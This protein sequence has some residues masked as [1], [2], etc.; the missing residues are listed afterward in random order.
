MHVLMP[1][2]SSTELYVPD[3]ARAMCY[4]LKYT[5]GITGKIVLPKTV[6]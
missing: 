3:G 2:R 5:G 4:D 6:A 1:Y